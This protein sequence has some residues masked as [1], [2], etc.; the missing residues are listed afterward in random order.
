[1]SI[2]CSY[3]HKISQYDFPKKGQNVWRFLRL[4]EQSVLILLWNSWFEKFGNVIFESLQLNH[5]AARKFYILR[6]FKTAI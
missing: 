4:Q 6:N 3:F 5:G 1:M 2:H